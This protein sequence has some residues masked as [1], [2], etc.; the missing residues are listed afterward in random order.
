MTPIDQS[1]QVQT[2]ALDGVENKIDNK[3]QELS[4]KID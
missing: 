1:N 4:L 2:D 3:I